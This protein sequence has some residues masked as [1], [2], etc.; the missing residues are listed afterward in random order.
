MYHWLLY[1]VFVVITTIALYI[2]QHETME[3]A[4]RIE[5]DARAYAD[6]VKAAADAVVRT[7]N[8]VKETA[9]AHAESVRKLRS[10]LD[11][12]MQEWRRL[13]TSLSPER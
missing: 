9:D 2:E 7:A 5:V 12:D 6:K 4:N 10:D 11:V 3:N 1:V 8:A 13:K